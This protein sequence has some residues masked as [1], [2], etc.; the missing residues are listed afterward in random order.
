MRAPELL[1][2]GRR[3][4]EQLPRDDQLLDLLGALEDV[5]DLDV[6]RPLL[7]QLA[8]AVADDPASATQRSAMS[9]PT[10]PAF[11]LA[12]DACSELGLRLSAIH[13]AWSVSRRAASQSDSIEMNSAAGAGCA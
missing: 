5:E 12:I 13:A 11:A 2:L 1:Q 4:A 10:R 9:V 7:E 6:A 8:L 3:L